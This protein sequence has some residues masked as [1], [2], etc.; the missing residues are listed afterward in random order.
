MASLTNSLSPLCM[1]QSRQS[2]PTLQFE[3]TTFSPEPSLTDHSHFDT[4]E[5]L[6][7]SR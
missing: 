2:I 4:S 7:V 3:F 6:D 5:S 1:T